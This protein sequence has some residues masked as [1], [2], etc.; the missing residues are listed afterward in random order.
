MTDISHLG[1]AV[2]GIPA[3]LPQAIDAGVETS[4]ASAVDLKA[5]R[6]DA[7]D[8]VNLYARDASPA[9]ETRNDGRSTR[10]TSGPGYDENFLGQGDR[11]PLPEITGPAR[12]HVLAY[13]DQG[14]TVR[15]YTHFSL[16][17]NR[18]RKLA[19]YTACN[20]DGKAIQKN[21][22]RAEWKI[23]E[24]IGAENQIHGS[25]YDNTDLDKGHLVRRL[26]VC[27]GTKAEA[28]RA[29]DETFHYT[30]AS[31]QHKVLNEGEWAQLENWLLERAEQKEKKLCVMT[32][33]VFR[34][35]DMTFHGEKIPSDFWKI[36]VLRKGSDN[37]MAACAFMMSQKEQ[38]EHLKGKND[39]VPAL[40][41]NNPGNNANPDKVDTSHVAVYQVPIETIEKLTNLN[42]GSLREVD[43]YSLYDE[44]K[45]AT[46][47]AGVPITI[48]E[49]GE[50]EVAPAA[51]RR[52]LIQSSKDIM[53]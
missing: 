6:D 40:F 2:S 31:P 12:E 39:R 18:E 20:L 37:K 53:I 47:N 22:K 43:A 27:W 44:R 42:F 26:D 52:R 11:V 3:T 14:D 51:E 48:T 17:M 16:V 24:T 50:M 23:D 25:V 46:L 10:R 28:K 30:N 21:I 34:D 36:V 32:G 13:N 4:D 9:S 38:L 35:N 41:S 45:T 7:G 5:P 1:S 49:G 15:Q 33:P 19:F 8:S 29:N